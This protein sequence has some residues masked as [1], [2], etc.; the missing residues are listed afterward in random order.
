MNLK[1]RKTFTWIL[2]AKSMI[3]KL[4]CV[5]AQRLGIEQGTGEQIDLV[6]KRNK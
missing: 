6:R 3:T 2:T 4:P 5:E 1:L